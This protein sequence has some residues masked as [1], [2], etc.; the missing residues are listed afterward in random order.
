MAESNI[1]IIKKSTGE[2][3]TVLNTRPLQNTN[4]DFLINL[5]ICKMAELIYI[6]ADDVCKY[7][8]Y[9]KTDKCNDGRC[10]GGIIEFLKKPHEADDFRNL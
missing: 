6:I 10:V 3:I 2:K 5:D 1:D 9:S 8:A 7:C 4:Y